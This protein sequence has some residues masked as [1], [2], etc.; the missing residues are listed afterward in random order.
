MEELE[1]QNDDLDQIITEDV[2]TALLGNTIKRRRQEFGY[3]LE[4]LS[5]ISKVSRGM[6]GLIE[7]GKTTPSIGI[8]WKIARALRSPISDLI[9]DLFLKT[10]KLIGK[11]DCKIVKLANGAIEV[12]YLSRE[13]KGKIG[14]YEITFNKGRF[15]L[16]SIFKNQ[17]DQ[18]LIVL[19][20]EFKVEFRDRTLKVVAGDSL[21]FIGSDLLYIHIDTESVVCVNWIETPQ[22]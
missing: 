15:T 6:L 5:Q 22:S 14:L 4:K 7:S 1:N 19:T 10:P 21:H 8:L 3:S 18:T 20:G 2:L 12:R 9:P 11:A 17:L 16:P 13:N